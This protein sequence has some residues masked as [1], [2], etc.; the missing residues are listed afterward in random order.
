[1]PHTPN[2][3][4]LDNLLRQ[5]LSALARSTASENDA[6]AHLLSV[7]I[8]IARYYRSCA[9][10]LAQCVV[11]Q[12]AAPI[13]IEGQSI[14]CPRLLIQCTRRDFI[15]SLPLTLIYLPVR[16][17]QIGLRIGYGDKLY[18]AAHFIQWVQSRNVWC[19]GGAGD[20]LQRDSHANF[21]R[22]ALYDADLFTVPT[23]TLEPL[24]G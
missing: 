8:R 3:S 11:E 22:R 21:L 1:M 5:S 19:I 12:S 9:D 20:E 13:E 24:H 17:D 18:E 23:M 6:N 10:I 16:I 7:L 2:A 14:L 4:P 15:T